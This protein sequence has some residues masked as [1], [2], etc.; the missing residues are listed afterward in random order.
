MTKKKAKGWKCFDKDMK[1]RGMQF[2]HGEIA[3][4]SGEIKMCKNGI[5]FHENPEHVFNYYDRSSRVF[6]VEAEDGTNFSAAQ[7][8]LEL[9][10]LE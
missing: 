3:E 2:T 7:D 8:Q 1:C 6:E 4:V 5:H 10:E 9:L